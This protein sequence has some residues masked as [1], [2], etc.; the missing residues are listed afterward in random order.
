MAPGSRRGR[1]DTDTLSGCG[2]G[3]LIDLM[4]MMMGIGLAAIPVVGW[5][6][7]IGF[8]GAGFLWPLIGAWIG[9]QGVE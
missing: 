6:L 4:S 2:C 1:L 5:I 7:A 9:S 3:C 8:I